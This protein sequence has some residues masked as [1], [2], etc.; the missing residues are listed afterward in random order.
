[1]AMTMTMMMTLEA[2][3]QASRKQ[4]YVAL[5]YSQLRVVACC[6]KLKSRRDD[7]Y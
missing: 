1:M 6:Y 2:I 4:A 5:L 3:A 7:L